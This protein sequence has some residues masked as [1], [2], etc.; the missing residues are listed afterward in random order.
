VE[1]IMA[2]REER[3]KKW[4]SK[5][6]PAVCSYESYVDDQTGPNRKRKKRGVIP[7]QNIPR[8]PETGII[9]AEESDAS[10]V[11]S[12]ASE[13]ERDEREAQEDEGISEGSEGGLSEGEVFVPKKILKKRR[14]RGRKNEADEGGVILNDGPTNISPE[15]AAQLSV[16]DGNR[17]EPK[18]KKGVCRKWLRGKCSLGKKC[19]YNHKAKE[20]A[21]P[22]GEPLEVKPRSF[23]AAVCLSMIFTDVQLLQSQMERE[24]IV[25]LQTLLHFRDHGLLDLK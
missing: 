9:V 14:K 16:S 8:D 12:D 5:I 25:L 23:Y 7:S 17:K 24:N 15:G 3:K 2:W 22:V 11:A 4:L 20:K 21:K 19:R 13:G 1:D 6:A 10:E 18:K